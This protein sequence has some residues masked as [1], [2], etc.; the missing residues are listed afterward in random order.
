PAGMHAAE[1]EL[2]DR[3]GPSEQLIGGYLLEVRQGWQNGDTVVVVV[4]PGVHRLV[5]AS[6]SAVGIV[7]AIHP[8]FADQDDIAGA[9][10][11]VRN[12]GFTTLIDN[13]RLSGTLEP[14]ERSVQAAIQVGRSR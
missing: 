12:A 4:V 3:N 1:T 2:G 10:V 11:D 9:V 8:A 5:V 14:G 6:V 13:T 7:G